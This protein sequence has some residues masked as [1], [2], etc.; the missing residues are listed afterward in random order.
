MFYYVYQGEPRK[1]F[2]TRIITNKNIILY[3]IIWAFEQ[4]LRRYG[5]SKLAGQLKTEMH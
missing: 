5:G 1:T 3:Y 2:G 4:S